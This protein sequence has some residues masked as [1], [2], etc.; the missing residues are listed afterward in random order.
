MH[1][2]GEV[3]DEVCSLSCSG[4]GYNSYLTFEQSENVADHIV[5]YSHDSHP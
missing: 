1:C 5:I 4:H 3:R 2:R